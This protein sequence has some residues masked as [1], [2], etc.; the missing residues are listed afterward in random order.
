MSSQSPVL[1]L[2]TV[3][4]LPLSISVYSWPRAPS[5]A[6]YP[7]HSAIPFFLFS[8]GVPTDSVVSI[9]RVRVYVYPR[10]YPYCVCAFA[11]S[12]KL[13]PIRSILGA[14]IRQIHTYIYMYMQRGAGLGLVY[15]RHI[16][17]HTSADWARPRREEWGV[18]PEDASLTP[19]WVRLPAVYRLDTYLSLAVR[20][21]R[22][23]RDVVLLCVFDCGLVCSGW[24]CGLRSTVRRLLFEHLAFVSHRGMAVMHD[25]AFL[26]KTESR[27]PGKAV[28]DLQTQLLTIEQ[29]RMLEQV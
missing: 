21:S 24:V 1:F 7:L 9:V 15:P 20:S 25:L 28:A 4:S 3:Y 11:A 18:V 2:V 29:L 14:Y 16:H 13:C 17:L 26:C 23:V 6:R 27:D 8:R 5:P 22:Y 19:V 12:L 10:P